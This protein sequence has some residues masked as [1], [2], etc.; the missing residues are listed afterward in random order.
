MRIAMLGVKSIP[1]GGGITTYTAE[2]GRRLVSRGHQVTVYCRPHYLDDPRCGEYSGIRRKLSPGFEGKHLDAPSHTFTAALD[3]LF[4]DYAI[5]HIHGL[6]PGFVGP[7]VRAFSR[8]RVV[9][10]V[11]ACDWMGSKWGPV[12]RRCMQG[13]VGIALR[14]A[15][16]V[17]TVSRGLQQYLKTE[18]GCQ[19]SYTPPGVTVPELTP[20]GEILKRGIEPN[21]Y[22]LCVSRLMPEK[23]IHYAV[24]A[25]ER[26]G[27]DFTLVIAG[28]CPYNSAYVDELRAHA[29]DRIRFLGRVSGR[30]LEE[31]YSHAYAFVQ[32]SDLEGLSIAVLEALSF[33]R[34]VLASD[35]PQNLE[36]LGG[37]GYTFEAGNVDDLAARLEWLLANPAAVEQEFAGARQYVAASYN[38][39]R[40]VDVFEGVYE[41]CLATDGARSC[42]S[43]DGSANSW[44]RNNR[45]HGSRQIA[46]IREA[47]EVLD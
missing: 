15:H 34:C 17:T 9:L 11:H 4:R 36:G 32:P 40:T 39:D 23:G 27:T 25:F 29:S 31:L 6:A 20:P 26:L 12:A 18:R 28:D 45:P 1:Y 19:A 13:V 10:T 44:L 43:G 21:R 16:A 37:H 24:E 7:M 42:P 2:I 47:D 3:S 33:G 38:W 5:L 14:S 22:V 41:A 46:P 8:K 30:L 35:I